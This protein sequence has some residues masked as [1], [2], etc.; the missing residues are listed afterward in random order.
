M[1]MEV[2]ELHRSEKS[3]VTLV[4]D[5][6]TGIRYVRKELKSSHPVYQQ[7]QSL[8]HHYL[9]K[10]VQLEQNQ[11]SSVLLEEYIDGANLAAITL[12]EKQ[13]V[14]LMEDLCE[15][16][17]FL[18]QHG[19]IHRDIKPSNLLLAPDGHI[20]LIDFDAA[21][22]EKPVGDSDTRLLGTKGYAPPEQYGFAQTDSRADIYAV[23]V[24]MKQ[25]LGKRGAVR[26]TA[27][28]SA[29]S[30]IDLGILR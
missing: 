28:V 4:I 5:P 9:P 10:I 1:L 19:I 8:Q 16:L 14:T 24:T 30:D 3:I 11:D 6:E 7:L 27:P 12:P 18:H 22:E 25:L 17:V 2:K 29:F 21:R 23:G 20:R 13:T 15:V 26:G